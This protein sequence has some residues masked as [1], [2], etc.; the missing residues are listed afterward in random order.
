M[1]VAER[2]LDRISDHLVE[3]T[4]AIDRLDPEKVAHGCLGGEHGYGA[5]WEN[6]VFVMRPYYWGEC[7]CG[8]DERERVYGDTHPH[9]IDCY[10]SDL[11]RM[12]E[13]HDRDSGYAEIERKAF[14]DDVFSLFG[15][16]DVETE[17]P[18][19]GVVIMMATPR[20]DFAMDAW[21]KASNARD[22]AKDRFYK[23]LCTEHKLPYPSG[24]AVHCTCGRDAAWGEWMKTNGHTEACSLFLPNFVHKPSGL[25]VEWYKYIG[26]GMEVENMPKDIRAVFRECIESLNPPPRQDSTK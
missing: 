17:S 26:R 10:Q 25:R 8:G 1:K 13:E 19:P 6:D 14:G 12:I 15:G 7:D 24:C 5:H 9:S 22:K 21:R 2:V 3:L 4:E 18:M 16:M 23:L 11:A 20:E